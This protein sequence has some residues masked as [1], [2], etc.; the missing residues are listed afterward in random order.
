MSTGRV[1]SA[2]GNGHGICRGTKVTLA[3]DEEKFNLGN[4]FLFSAVMDRF[5]GLYS[6]INSFSRTFVKTK[7]REGFLYEGKPRASERTLEGMDTKK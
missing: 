6:S 2:R 4:A 1:P 7:Q 5:L 3:L